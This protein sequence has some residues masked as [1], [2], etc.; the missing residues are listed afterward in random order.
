MDIKL[1]NILNKTCRSN[2]FLS[3]KNNNRR[4]ESKSRANVNIVIYGREYN[5]K[6]I[7]SDGIFRRRTRGSGAPASVAIATPP[8]W[9]PRQ[10]D[11]Y[12]AVPSLPQNYNQIQIRITKVSMI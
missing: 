8:V 11:V 9:Q 3:H 1:L 6:S 10:S 12:T 4:N 7:S 2:L 5:G